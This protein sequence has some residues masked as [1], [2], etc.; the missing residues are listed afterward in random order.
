MD[1]EFSFTKKHVKVGLFSKYGT[2]AR[3]ID[4]D[5]QTD[6]QTDRQNRK[7]SDGKALRPQKCAEDCFS[8]QQVH[9]CLFLPAIFYYVLPVHAF[10]FALKTT[11]DVI[12]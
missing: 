6:K 11:A 5:R 9:L 12:S 3:D 4:K 7:C 2:Q 10:R 1:V 8:P